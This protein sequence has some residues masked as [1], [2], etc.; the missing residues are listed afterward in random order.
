M[1]SK[2]PSQIFIKEV[3]I[4]EV[5]RILTNPF[6]SAIGHLSTAEVL[7]RMLGKKIEP[8]RVEVKVKEGDLVVVFQILKRIEE[9]KVLTDEE[10][11]AL[12]HKFFVIEVQ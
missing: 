8:N 10:V 11:R 3:D 1:L 9:G 5:K 12:P 4:E 6:I 2:F 7:S